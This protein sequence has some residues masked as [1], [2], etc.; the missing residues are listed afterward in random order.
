MIRSGFYIDKT[1]LLVLPGVAHADAVCWWL[2]SGFISCYIIYFFYLFLHS[3]SIFI[4]YF[5]L[6]NLF[7]QSVSSLYFYN[8]SLFLPAFLSFNLLPPSISSLCHPT[9]LPCLL[10]VCCVEAGYVWWSFHPVDSIIDSLLL[11]LILQ[12]IS[13][14]CFF[15][16]SLFLPAFLFFNLFL[17]SVSSL[18]HYSFLHCLLCVWW[19]TTLFVI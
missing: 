18:C 19:R 3:A 10:N 8:L 1:H 13:F 14:L 15:P 16:L 5:L 12:S 9:F 4:L 2:S 17:P 6:Y 11:I 7:L